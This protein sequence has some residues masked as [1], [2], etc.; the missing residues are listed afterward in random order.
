MESWVSSTLQ[1]A[2]IQDMVERVILPEKAIF[3]WRC[4][5]GVEFPLEDQ[6]ETV[7]F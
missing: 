7:V 3:G 1:E 5:I 2:D 4:Y 6:T